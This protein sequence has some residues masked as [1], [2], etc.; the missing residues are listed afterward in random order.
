MCMEE[1]GITQ[2]MSQIKG[3]SERERIKLP[4]HNAQSESGYSTEQSTSV[5]RHP[6]DLSKRLIKI[7]RILKLMLNVLRRL[8]T[9]S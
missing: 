1:H 2:N 4:A 9:T 6:E 8:Y 7:G 5:L 3:C